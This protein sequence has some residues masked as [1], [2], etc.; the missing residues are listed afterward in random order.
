MGEMRKRVRL[1]PSTLGPALPR[2]PEY[3]R[4]KTR[5]DCAAVPRP[6]PYVGCR[7]NLSLDVSRAGS[8][9][10]R[11]G[12]DFDKPEAQANCALDFADAGAQTLR[13]V[14]PLMGTTLGNVNFETQAAFAQLERMGLKDI[15]DKW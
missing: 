11:L 14:A 13:E 15:A 7:Y 12:V 4:P 9:R 10:Y 3:P 8:I 5:A 6:C 2:V 1:Q